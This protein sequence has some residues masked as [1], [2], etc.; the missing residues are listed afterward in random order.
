MRPVLVEFC[1]PLNRTSL[2]GSA[3]VASIHQDQVNFVEVEVDGLVGPGKVEY[4]ADVF[5]VVERL[6][7]LPI[8]DAAPKAYED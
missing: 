1:H 8:I 3:P 2:T 7:P 5:A 4:I 6:V